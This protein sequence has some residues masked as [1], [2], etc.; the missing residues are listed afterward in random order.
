[1]RT[2]IYA[3]LF[4]AALFPAAARAQYLDPD[5]CWNC[6]DK[7]LHFVAGAS[8][9]VIVRGPWTAP[10]WR[11][12]AFKRIALTCAVGAAYEAVQ[13][14]EAVAEHRSGP[15]YGFSPLDLAADCAGAAGMELL[16]AGVRRL[17]R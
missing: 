17:F 2:R 4:V 15:G 8:I 9:D 14:A 6:L 10:T 11:N 7:Q 16:W 1:M 12:T 13:V 3:L 5:R